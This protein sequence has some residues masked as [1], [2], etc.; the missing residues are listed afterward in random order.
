MKYAIEMDSGGMIYVPGF[1]KIDPGVQKVLWEGI[2]V[3][4]HMQ[5][6]DLVCLFLLFQNKKGRLK[7]Y[8]IISKIK[9]C[10]M[11]LIEP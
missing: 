8:Y 9:D 7:N 11:D 2:L 5:Q 3:R 10:H 6:G 4:T 1:I